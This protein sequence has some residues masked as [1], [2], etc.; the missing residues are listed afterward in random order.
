M[1]LRQK[2]SSGSRMCSCISS[3]FVLGCYVPPRPEAYEALGFFTAAWFACFARVEI[4]SIIHSFSRPWCTLRE[5][6]SRGRNVW[7]EVFLDMTESH[8]TPQRSQLRYKGKVPS[9]IAI[10]HNAQVFWKRRWSWPETVT[11]GEFTNTWKCHG[12][13]ITT[14]RMTP[15]QSLGSQG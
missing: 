6:R 10:Q 4:G 13:G 3:W 1:I 7:M 15:F 8:R 9:P 5:G 11:L 12:D 14:D 2:E